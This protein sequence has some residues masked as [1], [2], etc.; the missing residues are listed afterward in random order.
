MEISLKSLLGKLNPLTKNDLEAAISLCMS[1]RHSVVELEHWLIKLLEQDSSAIRLILEY[2]S[3][4]VAQILKE[5]NY[6]QYRITAAPNN[7][8]PSLARS[9]V[10]T[11]ENSWLIAS[12]DFNDREIHS[13]HLFLAV[14]T[15][16][17]SLDLNRDIS[18][19][20]DAVDLQLVKNNFS[21]ILKNCIEVKNSGATVINKGNSALA[22]FTSDLVEAAHKKTLDRAIGRESELS[23]IIDILCRRKQNNPIL[24]GE[25]GVGKTAIVEELAFR[26]AE[27]LVPEA[28]KNASLKVLDLAALQ[29][30]ANIKGE[31]EQRLKNILSEI[32][33]ATNK[34]ILFIDEV[35]NIVGAGNSGQ[36]DAA[37]LLKP[38][39]ARGEISVIGATTW[40]EYKRYFE[41]DSALN[42]RFQLI[43]VKEPSEEEAMAIARN[44]AELLEKHHGI[45]ILEQSI[46]AAVKLSSRYITNMQLPDKAISL[47]DSAC[48]RVRLQ[49][50]IPSLELQQLKETLSLFD[51]RIRRL[52]SENHGMQDALE[53]DLISRREKLAQ[54][55]QQTCAIWQQQLEIVNDLKRLKRES[56]LTDYQLKYLALQELNDQ[57]VNIVHEHVDHDIIANIISAM[58]GIPI[59][60][61][62]TAKSELEELLN[63]DQ[64]LQKR[65]VGQNHGI[66][67]IVQNIRIAKANMSDPRKPIGVFF[68]VGESGVGKTE[69]ALSLAE[70][71]Y[72]TERK[73]ITINMSE[74][75]EA[76]KVSSLIGSPPGYVGYGEG[77]KLTE[78]VRRNPYSV[79]LL[80]E[81]E[82]A[83]PDVQELFLQVFD[84]G[85]LTDSEGLEINFKNLIIIMTSNLG[86]RKIG[87]YCQKNKEIDIEEL[88]FS[89]K[90][91]L[92]GSFKPE[93]LG[94]V[95]VIPYLSLNDEMLRQIIEIQLN[96]IRVRVKE[97]YKADFSYSQEVVDSLAA[98]SRTSKIGARIIEHTISDSIL[99]DL[100]IN[101]LEAVSLG[102]IPK[103]VMLE[104]AHDKFIVQFK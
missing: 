71:I 42:R 36:N 72:G 97:H 35:H 79:L 58:T 52:N 65:V 43:K 21:E 77:G 55:Y 37:N 83:H 87:E 84:K 38:E 50:S 44:A 54:Q 57:K 88:S 80:D 47:L 90:E 75:K 96:K 81:M 76:H 1:K 12:L 39:L 78:Q 20:F 74:Y 103:L 25:A 31:F 60:V 56:N 95:N 9:L 45:N 18:K 29:A 41:K 67:K 92:L 98:S 24:V 48:T 13:G 86:A 64:K 17:S 19:L 4:D 89:I 8:V 22:V 69:T 34:V 28:L 11:M 2:F 94:R 15:N 6:V 51:Q 68:L 46:E 30:G 61:N 102:K 26:I 99:P 100:S 27:G 49:Q 85:S 59:P 7:T 93:F 104:V 73:I 101:L 66:K 14:L 16:L 23:Q 53:L 32:K 3:V 10:E 40:S 91:S 70:A 82:K 62:Q 5:L 33:N 63:L